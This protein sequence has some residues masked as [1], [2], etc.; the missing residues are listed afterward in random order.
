MRQFVQSSIMVILSS[1][2]IV[3]AVM[4]TTWFTNSKIKVE[5]YFN[6]LEKKRKQ[7][8]LEGIIEDQIKLIEELNETIKN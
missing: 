3:P 7:D 8:K 4:K 2:F 5:N 6:E 1:M